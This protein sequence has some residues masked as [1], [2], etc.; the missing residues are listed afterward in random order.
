LALRTE[1]RHVTALERGSAQWLK[2]YCEEANT[3]L[4]QTKKLCDLREERV[5]RSV[6][7]I[8]LLS[9]TYSDRCTISAKAFAVDIDSSSR[10]TLTGE[11][12]RTRPKKKFDVIVTDPPY[13][14]N[15]EVSTIALADLLTG[16]LDVFFDSIKPRAQMVIALPDQSHS[17][18]RIPRFA[19][20][21][22]VTEQILSKAEEHGF[23]AVVPASILPRYG[24]LF[25]PPYYWNSEKALKRIILHFQFRKKRRPGNGSP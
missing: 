23:E 20:R 25:Q 5:K 9:G 7:K 14:F 13:G 17:G 3:L 15:N 24:G 18:R 12:A 6:G 4:F 16:M 10:L 8:M 19:T 22:W 2:A 11:D 21:I 1:L